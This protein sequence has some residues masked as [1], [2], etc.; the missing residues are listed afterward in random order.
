VGAPQLSRRYVFDTNVVVSALLFE[1]GRLAWLRGAWA[2]GELTPV[3]SAA[4]VAEL[5]R[6][7][8]YPK[9]GLEPGDREELLGDVLP[10]AELFDGDPARAPIEATDPA[11]QAFVDLVV[12]SGATALVTGDAALLALAPRVPVVRPGDLRPLAWRSEEKPPPG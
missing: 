4:T 8:A 1:A 5:I 7:L 3:V 12:A 9:F 6:V 10:Y 2:D 11:D